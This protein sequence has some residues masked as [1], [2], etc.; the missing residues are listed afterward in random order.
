MSFDVSFIRLLSAF[1]KICSDQGHPD[2][3]NFGLNQSDSRIL[4]TSTTLGILKVISADF[5]YLLSIKSFKICEKCFLFRLKSFLG[6]QDMQVFVCFPL[7]LFIV[8]WVIV[9]AVD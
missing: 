7:L 2:V 5:L 8:V 3:L 9:A 6:F 4:E 1:L